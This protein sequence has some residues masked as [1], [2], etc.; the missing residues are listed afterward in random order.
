[1]SDQGML[2]S[3]FLANGKKLGLSE[4]LLLKVFDYLEQNRF[5]PPG[6]RDHIRNG[7]LQL[8]RKEC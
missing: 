4:D 8:I 5:V 7:L 6:D 3:E 1:M 2:V